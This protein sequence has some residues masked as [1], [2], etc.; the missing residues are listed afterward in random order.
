MIC[1]SRLLVAVCAT[2]H[3]SAFPSC[4]V[5]TELWSGTR[6][7]YKLLHPFLTC[8]SINVV[9]ICYKL[10]LKP[11]LWCKPCYCMHHK[12]AEQCACIAQVCMH[13]CR[14]Q[15]SM[16][17]LSAP[18]SAS[19]FQSCLGPATSWH[20]CCGTWAPTSCLQLHKQMLMLLVLTQ[21]PW[22]MPRTTRI[23]GTPPGLEATQASFSGHD[24]CHTTIPLSIF[25]VRV[26]CP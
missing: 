24:S 18:G 14:S 25:K 10:S 1:W 8:A 4:C 2:R 20:V 22:T 15:R 13:V 3:G 7:R 17:T 12:T 5:C 26:W 23:C 16:Q 21:H 6:R 9:Q 11:H 19:L